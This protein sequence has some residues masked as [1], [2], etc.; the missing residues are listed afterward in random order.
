MQV[1]RQLALPIEFEG[2]SI[3]AG[4]RLDLLVEKKVVIEVKA[5]DKLMPIHVAQMVTYLRLGGNPLGYIL[6]FIVLH[7]R[8][9]IGRIVL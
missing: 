8:H 6:N 2:K 1:K 5:V 7:M 9:G 4:Y 3:E